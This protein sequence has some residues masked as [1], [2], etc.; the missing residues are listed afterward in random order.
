MAAVTGSESLGAMA[1]EMRE[2]SSQ[3]TENYL[4]ARILWVLIKVF[5]LLEKHRE[6]AKH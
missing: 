2:E 6:K 3:W 1:E 4:T 5:N